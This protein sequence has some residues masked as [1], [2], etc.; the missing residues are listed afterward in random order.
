MYRFE[1]RANKRRFEATPAR[2]EPA[3]GG[4]CAWAMASGY[5]VRVDP[6]SF[7]ITDATLR[8]FYRNPLVDTRNKWMRGDDSALARDAASYWRDRSGEPRPDS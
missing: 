7:T 4:W 5:R 8:L 1:P 6:E 2:Y 3:Y